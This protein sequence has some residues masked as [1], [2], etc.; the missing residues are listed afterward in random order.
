MFPQFSARLKKIH[1]ISAV[2]AGTVVAIAMAVTFGVFE[3]FEIAIFD[4]FTQWNDSAAGLD[5]RILVVTIDE[6]DI[7]TAGSWP[8]SDQILAQA[9]REI[10]QYDPANVGIDLYRNLPVAPGTEELHDVFATSPNVIG[11]GRVVGETVLP[12]AVLDSLDQTAASDLVVD[13]D[14]RIRRGLLSVIT[15]TGEVKQGLATVLALRYLADLDIEPEVIESRRLSLQVG[16]GI[17]TRF[18]ENDGGYVKADPGGFQVL[19]NYQGSSQQFESVSLTS[20]LEGELKD[21]LVRDRIVLIGATGISLNDLFRTPPEGDSKVAGVYVHAHLV[22]QLLSVALEGKPFMRVVPDSVEWL[23][24][25]GWVV[26]AF[27]VSRSMFYTQSLKSDVSAA[28]L[29]ARLVGLGGSLGA[30]GYGLFVAGWWFP[31]ALPLVAI[32]STIVLGI[33]YRN[34]QLQRLAAFDELTQVANR[35]YFDQSLAEALK[36]HKQLSLILCDVDY[37]KAFNDRYGHPAGDRCLQQVAHA[38]T[39]AVRDSDL[40]AR[41]GGEEFVIVLPNTT[42]EMAVTIADRIQQEVGQLE[43]QHEGSQVSEWVTLSCGAASVSPGFWL[44]PL[45]LIEYAD[46]A[47]Y[48]AKQSGRNRVVSSQWQL[49]QGGEAHPEESA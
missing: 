17:V 24:T 37:F 4:Q 9:I 33:G 11:I 5:D 10:N 47:L 19:M 8:V 30:A 23:W 28:A 12:H 38:I 35:R 13:T 22:N 48:E 14:G 16:K 26:V 46:Q 34:F 7:E 36:G 41:Y 32:V 6:K 3:N 25:L 44:L 31:V 20:V 15:S 29:L 40:V 27:F 42:A 43:I 45:Q 39:L 21:E 18:E 2:G 1:Q 49:I